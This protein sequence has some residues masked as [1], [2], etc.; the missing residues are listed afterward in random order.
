MSLKLEFVDLQ[1]EDGHGGGVE[2]GDLVLPEAPGSFH[3]GLHRKIHHVLLGV[4]DAN[5]FF[6][7]TNYVAN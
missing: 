3:S 6:S 4:N 7:V 1:I 2:A 5:N